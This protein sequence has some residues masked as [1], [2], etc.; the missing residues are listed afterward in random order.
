ML[1]MPLSL[2]TSLVVLTSNAGS[3]ITAGPIRVTV[4]VGAVAYALLFDTDVVP[5]VDTLV[6]EECVLEEDEEVVALLEEVPVRVELDVL[7]VI[8]NGVLVL[9]L[10][11]VAVNNDVVNIVLVVEAVERVLVDV[12]VAV[13]VVE[14]VVVVVANLLAMVMVVVVVV[15]ALNGAQQRREMLGASFGLHTGGS[16]LVLL[17]NATITPFGTS[18]VSHRSAVQIKSL[19]MAHPVPRATLLRNSSDVHSRAPTNAHLRAA[20]AKAMFFLKQCPPI[21]D[22]PHT[23]VLPELNFHPSSLHDFSCTAGAVVVVVSALAASE[24]APGVVSGRV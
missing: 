22:S 18:C 15:T 13:V 24:P 20:S 6:V 10:D 11:A 19:S 5:L 3:E 8:I 17:P 4:V 14:V 21:S 23:S 16:L 1:S 7:D 2:S 12:M 9:V